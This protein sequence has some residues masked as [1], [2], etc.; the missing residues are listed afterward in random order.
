[1][2]KTQ[3]ESTTVRFKQNKTK[4]KSQKESVFSLI[5]LK[6]ELEWSESFTFN[7]LFF[8]KLQDQTSEK[9]LQELDD[10]W[11]VG[12]I[13]H[14]KTTTKNLVSAVQATLLLL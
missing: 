12:F 1:M 10:M 9:S 6:K 8:P 14:S 13:H 4:L 11:M 2:D 3:N 5:V 7:T